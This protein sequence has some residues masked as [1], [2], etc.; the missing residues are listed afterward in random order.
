M[1]R[2]TKILQGKSC[3]RARDY[4]THKSADGKDH[5]KGKK[6]KGGFLFVSRLKTIENTMEFSH[7]FISQL[8]PLSL[9]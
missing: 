2:K 9:S 3:I 4:I 8:R 6:H 7:L 5:T 1:S